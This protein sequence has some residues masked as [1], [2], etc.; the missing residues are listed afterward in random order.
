[1]RR[2]SHEGLNSN[3][4]RN[5]YPAQQKEAILLVQNVLNDCNHWDDELKR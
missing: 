2:A 1:M 4:A 3:Y 5:Y